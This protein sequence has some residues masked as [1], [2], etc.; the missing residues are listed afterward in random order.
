L[1]SSYCDN[2]FMTYG[3]RY[4]TLNSGS[5]PVLHVLLALRTPGD[6]Q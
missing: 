2:L 5:Q 4:D 1:Y 6:I 3:V